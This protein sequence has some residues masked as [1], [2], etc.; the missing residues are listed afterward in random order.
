MTQ[1]PLKGTNLFDVP[2]KFILANACHL[3]LIFVLHSFLYEN[4]SLWVELNEKGGWFMSLH[5]GNKKTFGRKG[6]YGS[7]RRNECF[8][9]LMSIH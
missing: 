1:F 3:I 8:D 7:I 6:K 5:V 2:L 9:S 4:Y